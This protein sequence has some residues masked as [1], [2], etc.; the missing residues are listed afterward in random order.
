MS[1]SIVFSVDGQPKGKG[2]P[3]FRR[4]G[5]FVSTYTDSKTRDYE[6]KIADRA[7]IAMG[8]TP[9][10]L[11]PV[12]VSMYF[13]LPVPTSTPKK[14]VASLLG[15]LVRPTK[16]PDLDNLDKAVLDALNGIVY[17]D[18]S[19]VVTIHSKKVY[20]THAGVDICIMEEI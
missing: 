16:K 12:S 10:L 3:R 1:I 15:G 4:V 19:Q 13:R 9:P 17:K 14:R 8:E 7:R 6:S 5:N 18:D 11:S 20:S 2:R